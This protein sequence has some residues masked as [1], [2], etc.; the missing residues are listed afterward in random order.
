MTPSRAFFCASLNVEWTVWRACQRALAVARSMLS[1]AISITGMA[2]SLIEK[3][4]R[5]ARARHLE[6]VCY[7]IGAL[8]LCFSYD[9]LVRL[10]EKQN[11]PAHAKLREHLANRRGCPTM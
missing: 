1:L 9:L 2:F 11:G 6:M 4:R 3:S 5:A 7:F 8:R 10:Y